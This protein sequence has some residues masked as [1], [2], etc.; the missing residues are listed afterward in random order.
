MEEANTKL[1]AEMKRYK[2]YE[3]MYEEEKFSKVK[4]EEQLMQAQ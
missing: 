1:Q 4:L 2:H 3:F